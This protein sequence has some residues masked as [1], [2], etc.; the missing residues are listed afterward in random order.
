MAAASTPSRTFGRSSAHA[1]DRGRHGP[2][3]APPWER[4]RRYE[5]YP[6]L[7]TK[8]G[9]PTVQPLVAAVVA[10]AIAALALFFIPPLLLNLGSGAGPGASASASAA[11][12]SA[13]APASPTAVAAPTPVVY[14][15]KSGDTLSKIAKK[16]GV[17]VDQLVAA[18]KETIKDPDKIKL[19]DRIT[20]P[21]PGAS[22]LPDA[23]SPSPS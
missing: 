23:V 15:V 16:F 20:I 7:K 21:T 5:A 13:A 10:I 9:M 3:D 22:D 12:A 8:V 1:A 18:N 4:P 19:G 14:V 6:T 11:A 17:T 2:E